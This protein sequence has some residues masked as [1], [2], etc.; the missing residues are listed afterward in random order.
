MLLSFKPAA[1]SYQFGSTMADYG[2]LS[3]DGQILLP[4]M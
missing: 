2:W 3:A 4:F 1:I